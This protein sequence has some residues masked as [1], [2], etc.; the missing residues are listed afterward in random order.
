MYV[1][2]LRADVSGILDHYTSHIQ[3]LLPLDEK[4]KGKKIKVPR[5]LA[6]IA[7]GAGARK[8]SYHFQSE[9]N[10]SPPGGG[11]FDEYADGTTEKVITPKDK[12]EVRP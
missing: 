11:R 5:D 3:M 6:E 8:G 12:E 1:D 2:F 7:S 9:S 4:D 10:F